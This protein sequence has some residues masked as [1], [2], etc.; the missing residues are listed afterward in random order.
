MNASLCIVYLWHS[1]HVDYVPAHQPE[2]VALRLAGEPGEGGGQLSTL[3]SQQ[4]I[5]Y[6]HRYLSLNIKRNCDIFYI[7][8]MI[9]FSKQLKFV[10]DSFA[11]APTYIECPGL[12]KCGN[13]S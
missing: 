3:H 9:N 1:G 10:K 11:E 7:G 2:H 5:R 12:S 4:V 6:L 13:N 8:W